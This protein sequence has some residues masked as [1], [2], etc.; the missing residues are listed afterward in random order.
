MTVCRHAGVA[1]AWGQGSRHAGPPPP[2]RPLSET[3][4]AR[5][6]QKE[7]RYRTELHP[8]P[9]LRAAPTTLQP[10]QLH[11]CC[12]LEAVWLCAPY[13][14]R[15]GRQGMP[16]PPP[17]PRHAAHPLT[18]A[19]KK[20]LRTGGEPAAMV[21]GRALRW[22]PRVDVVVLVR[23]PLCI[24]VRVREGVCIGTPPPC[25]VAG[26]LATSGCNCTSGR[27]AACCAVHASSVAEYGLA[28]A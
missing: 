10:P 23:F 2:H 6:R 3:R 15:T 1:G 4:F 26:C 28:C 14:A 12:S 7:D 16:H 11:D 5:K 20:Y 17:L 27:W 24:I 21:P 9:V 22:F 25:V 18:I 19:G 8:E 13:H